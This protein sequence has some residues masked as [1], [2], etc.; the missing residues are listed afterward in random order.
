MISF[1]QFNEQEIYKEI[2]NFICGEMLLEEVELSPELKNV[3][4][5][6]PNPKDDKITKVE[7]NPE[8]ADSLI[9]YRNNKK[10]P[11]V[12]L[13]RVLKTL[14][15]NKQDGEIAKLGDKLKASLNINK[16]YDWELSDDV[17]KTYLS[18][19]CP[20]SCLTKA[21]FKTG[22]LEF[23]N[24]QKGKIKILLLKHNDKLVGRALIWYDVK[25]ANNKIL[26]DR[27]Y[28]FN[29]ENIVKRF[30][31]YALKQN[32]SYRDN[33]NDPTKKG[34]TKIG[35]SKTKNLSYQC[36]NLHDISVVP[37]LDTFRFG[38]SKG[39]F[40]NTNSDTMNFEFD[41]PHGLLFGNTE[42]IIF[43]GHVI[44]K[45]VKLPNGKWKCEDDLIIRHTKITSLADLNVEVV[46]GHFTCSDNPLLKS[47]TG[48]PEKATYFTCNDC[49]SLE[50][51]DCPNTTVIE[52]F[53]CSYNPLLKSLKGAPK[54]TGNFYCNGCDLL[55]ELN[56]SNTIVNGMF[57]CSDNPSL[58]SVKGAPK[59]V[60]AFDCSNCGKKFTK[61]EVMAVSSIK[62]KDDIIIW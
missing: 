61:E 59:K 38:N 24:T 12:K 29:D 37:Y 9:V 46:N 2:Y 20:S 62:D 53:S 21:K 50:S 32:W 51:L 55:D 40:T 28:P 11:P 6:T 35:N 48:A 8:A 3:L 7:I 41:K 17:V 58:K 13:N 33:V 39:L 26:M 19:D 14:F 23:F 56:C 27:V 4:K 49:E 22:S 18:N 47:L 10:Q 1:K 36:I 25:G 34:F 16:G 57:N 30:H 54:E 45:G 52:T 42:E 44:G 31:D 43:N 5:D 60:K 15:P